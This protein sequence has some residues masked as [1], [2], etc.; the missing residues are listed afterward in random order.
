[1]NTTAPAMSGDDWERLMRDNEKSNALAEIREKPNYYSILPAEIRYS[2]DLSWFEK[3]LYAEITAL[4]NKEGYCYASNSYLSTSFNISDKTITRAVKELNNKGLIFVVYEQIGEKTHRKIYLHDSA[5]RE[6]PMIVEEQKKT[7]R[8][9]NVQK[10]GTVLSK[11]DGQKCPTN[12]I[13]LNNKDNNTVTPLTEG[14]VAKPTLT[15]PLWLG[16]NSHARLGR[17]YELLW[18]RNMGLPTKVKLLGQIG[19]L[20]KR[21][22]AEHSEMMVALFLIVHFEWRGVSGTDGRAY[23]MLK[24]SAFPLAWLPT[25]VDMYRVFI[26]N[27]MGVIDEWGAQLLVLKAVQKLF[28]KED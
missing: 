18:E 4:S 7:A 19:A 2:K 12:N 13:V 25:R 21:L 20:F 16:N 23:S 17:L 27:Q 1:M 26:N 10:R 15:L 22:L 3:I 6:I 24:D 5:T 11:S 28:K 8:D 14:E 9:K